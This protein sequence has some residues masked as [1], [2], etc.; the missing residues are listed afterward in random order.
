MT[1]PVTVEEAPN[2]APPAENPGAPKPR[3]SATGAC[4]PSF[5]GASVGARGSGLRVSFDGGPATVEILQASAGRRAFAKPRRVARLK[6]S[7]TFT[8]DG[9][10]A[11]RAGVY[12]VRLKRGGEVRRF[13]VE[14]RGKRF[15]IAQAP[16]LA[17]GCGS[18]RSFG[19]RSPA[20]G[21]RVPLVATV[22]LSDAT[23]TELLVYRGKKVVKRSLG[24]RIRL[25]GRVKRGVYRVVLR[26]D[27]RAVSSATA[28]RV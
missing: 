2:P 12:E 4:T 27:G 8:W 1:L 17:P 5:Q 25:S 9:L 6:R 23:Q 18:V 3:R 28:R 24:P 22:K 19:V 14:R 7:G 20:L 15:A 11:R 13:T 26:V 21:G 16:G 10:K